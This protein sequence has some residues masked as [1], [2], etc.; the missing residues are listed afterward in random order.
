M[1]G[2]SFRNLRNFITYVRILIFDSLIIINAK[3]EE[4]EYDIKMLKTLKR[5]FWTSANEMYTKNE[6]SIHVFRVVSFHRP[7]EV[8]AMTADFL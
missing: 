7:F 6:I 4:L 2:E 1:I 8:H 5:S 3:L